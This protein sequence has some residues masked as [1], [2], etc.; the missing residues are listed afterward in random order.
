MASKNKRKKK[1]SKGQRDARRS[2]PILD[3]HQVRSFI[4]VTV[5]YVISV[6]ILALLLGATFA[7][8]IATPI[9]A[10]LY[11]IYPQMDKESTPKSFREWIRL[12]KFPQLN[13]WNV[14]WVV[15]TIFVIQACCGFIIAAYADDQ[16]D[17][18]DTLTAI[19]ALL[20]SPGVLLVF[21]LGTLGSYLGG[22]YIAGKLP[23]LKCP[24]P[25]RHGI[26]ATII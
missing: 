24:A 16:P 3:P 20:E 26:V 23:N 18:V 19:S 12:V 21:L 4:V 11:V 25:Y 9:W 17:S 6:A 7:T 10:F 8:I 15:L 1:E 13:Y 14:F 22:G 5:A 2:K